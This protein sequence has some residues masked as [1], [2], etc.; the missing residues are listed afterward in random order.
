MKI[1]SAVEKKTKEGAHF[2]K[3]AKQ[4]LWNGVIGA[5]EDEFESGWAKESRPDEPQGC[6]TPSLRR[7]HRDDTG[8]RRLQAEQTVEG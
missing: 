8:C 6:S 2:P 1:R 4:T 7:N 5:Y 3:N